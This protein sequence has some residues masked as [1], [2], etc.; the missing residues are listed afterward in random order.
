MSLAYADAL[1]YREDLGGQCGAPELSE[2]TPA[3]AAAKADALVDLLAS[4]AAAGAGGVVAFTGAGLSTA[5][6]IPD[7]RG[8]DG[9]W[10]RQRDGRPPPSMMADA[11]GAAAC[12]SLARPT[13]AHAAL[14]ALASG[15]DPLVRLVV[16]QNVDGLHLRAGTP[17]ARLAELHGNVFVEACARP[18]CGRAWVRDFETGSVGRRPTPR[19]CGA[20]GTGRLRDTTLDWEQALPA[21][22]L[23]AA[24]DASSGAALAL[25]LGTSL[26]IVPACDLPLRTVAA[27]GAL[28]IVNLQATPKDRDA[29]VVLRGRC[30]EV[31]R[32]VMADLAG[33]GLAPAA[34]P[35]WVRTDAVVV[36]ASLSGG[37]GSAPGAA[38]RARTAADAAARGRQ[39]ATLLVSLHSPAGEGDVFPVVAMV[40]DLEVW[41]SESGGGGVDLDGEPDA[42]LTGPPWRVRLPVSLG[43]G[44]GGGGGEGDET[45]GGA[46]ALSIRAR[47]GLAGAADPGTPRPV[48]DLTLPASPGAAVREVVRFESQRVE[49]GAHL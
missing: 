23:K 36:S 19:R 38:K 48:V 20:C 31:M 44:G 26:Q 18:A 24:E 6:G 39:K 35:P 49:W 16:S 28:A 32:R 33:R 7:F 3:E 46:A 25:A 41:V 43:G 9:V 10:T 4:A 14:A 34:L 1:T 5:A 22:E 8:P 47:L 30:D 12:F 45:G 13:Y 11:G 21:R 42:V 29:A 15:P 40:A 27:G 37:G 2:K 17:P